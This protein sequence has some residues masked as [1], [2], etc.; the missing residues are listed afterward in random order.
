[1]ASGR[2]HARW[3]HPL[4]VPQHQIVCSD[5]S[6]SAFLVEPLVMQQYA[7]A[8]FHTVRI[9]SSH[10]GVENPFNPSTQVTFALAP[11]GL[12]SHLSPILGISHLSNL[13]ADEELAGSP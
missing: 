10:D 6:S 8:P 5:P 12:G 2:L 13:V 7:G 4:A 3:I 1:M 9:P 11:P